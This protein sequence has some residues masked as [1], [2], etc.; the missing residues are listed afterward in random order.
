MKPPRFWSNSPRRPGL[1]AIALTPLSW[2]YA[3]MGRIRRARAT[4]LR[5][6]APVICVGNIV[7]GGAG[8]TPT[9]LAIAERAKARG[10]TPHFL[11]R[12]YGGKI[13]GPHPVDPGKDASE[14]VGDEPLLL[15]A[16]HPTWVGKDRKA[17]AAAAVQAGADLLIMDDGF[18]NP[19]IEQD[20]AF[21]VI[22]AAFGHGNGRVIP[23]GPLRE[24][25]MSA[26]GRADAAILIGDGNPFVPRGVPVL[27]ARLTPRFTGMSFAGLRVVAF[28]GIGRP[29]KFFDTLLAM[30]AQVVDAVPFPDH[31][32]FSSAILTRLEQR[33]YAN[34]ATLVTTEKDAVRL[35]AWFRGRAV[36]VPVTLGFEDPEE[37]DLMLDTL[38]RP[39]RR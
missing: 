29:E 6:R 5:P 38:L 33:A 35:P 13:K 17:T 37:L 3:M 12:G 21:V 24:P 11:S 36:T 8:K 26:F 20:L 4:P 16:H 28:A 9:A 1:A 32:K 10:R 34:D 2:I 27:R 23:A 19:D 15:A 22:D 39:T 18:Q 7:A 31:H 14:E 25:I 30:G